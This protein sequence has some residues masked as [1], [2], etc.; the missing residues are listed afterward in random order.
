MIL[1]GV[2]NLYSKA[3]DDEVVKDDKDSCAFL[4]IECIISDE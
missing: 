4:S 1:E 2:D 3:I